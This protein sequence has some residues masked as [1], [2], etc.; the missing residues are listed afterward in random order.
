M[1]VK[2]SGKKVDNLM[3]RRMEQ[4]MRFNI[5]RVIYEEELEY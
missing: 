2:G 3:G 1:I 5:S 4:L